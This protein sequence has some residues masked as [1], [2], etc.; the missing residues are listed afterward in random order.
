MAKESLVSVEAANITIEKYIQTYF[1]TGK[2]PIKSISV[3]AASLRDYL[4]NHTN[5]SNLKIVL[6]QYSE[7]TSSDLTA[8]L[9]G[10]D[11][12]GNYVINADNTVLNS[13]APCPNHCPSGIAGNDLIS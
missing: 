4:N 9:V 11:S 5:I 6:A 3:D 2:F 10:Y 1:N 13:G 12:N 8:V 7:G